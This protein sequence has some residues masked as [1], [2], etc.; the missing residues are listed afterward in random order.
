V[1][2]VPKEMFDTESLYRRA[3]VIIRSGGLVILPTET[4]YALA[5]S[6]FHEETVRRV[7]RIKRR[8]E[9]TPLPLIASDIAAVN[10]LVCR[11]SPLERK[12]TD[13]FWPGSLT[14]LLVPSKQV[15]TLLM[16]PEGKIGIRIPP[17]CP[18]RIVAARVGGWLTATSANLSGDPSPDDV[19]KIAKDVLDAVDMVMDLGPTPGGKPST[20]VE[21]LDGDCRVLREGAVPESALRDY[22]MGK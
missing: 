9:G 2:Q 10:D 22:C 18:A 1:Q 7:F 12:L 11:M 6:P 14:I 8:E 21:L 19:S 16:G 20:V 5:A 15:S 17:E 3:G 4:F 13:G